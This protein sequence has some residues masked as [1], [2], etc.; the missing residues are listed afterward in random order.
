MAGRHVYLVRWPEGYGVLFNGSSL[1]EGTCPDLVEG[2]KAQAAEQC[3]SRPRVQ[4]GAL[5]Y[6][7]G[8]LRVVL[9]HRFGKYRS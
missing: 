9:R 5:T 3:P 4:C 2:G 6:G 8:I 7:I 1:A